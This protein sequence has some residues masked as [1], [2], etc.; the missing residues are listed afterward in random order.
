MASVQTESS[1]FNK[2]GSSHHKKLPNNTQGVTR[3]VAM[4]A[5]FWS[6]LIHLQESIGTLDLIFSARFST[7]IF[8]DICTCLTYQR[9]I[10]ESDQQ[11]TSL[12]VICIEIASKTAFICSEESKHDNSSS[13]GIDNKPFEQVEQVD[14]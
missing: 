9:A 6:A 5:G 3:R 13:R 8:Q 1:I 12:I 10:C 14:I 7:Q 11:N 2:E 4:S